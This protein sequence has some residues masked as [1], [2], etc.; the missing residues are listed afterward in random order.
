MS[1]TQGDIPSRDMISLVPTYVSA[2]DNMQVFLPSHLQQILIPQ[3]SK[4]KEN[5]IIQ[6][7]IKE[8]KENIHWRNSTKM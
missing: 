5:W 6:N 1:K 4:V 7:F 2:S 3:F 8:E